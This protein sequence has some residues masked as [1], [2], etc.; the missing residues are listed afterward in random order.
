[1]PDLVIFAVGLFTFLLLGGGL[2]FT[3]YEFR[4]M[5]K[6]QVKRD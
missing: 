4:R 6:Q 1:M 5:D 3:V 2:G